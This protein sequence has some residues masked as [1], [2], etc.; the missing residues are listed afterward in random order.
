[1]RPELP[2][3]RKSG[4]RS[5]DTHCRPRRTS[6]SEAWR[7]GPMAVSRDIAPPVWGASGSGKERSDLSRQI[8]PRGACGPWRGGSRALCGHRPFPCGYGN[9]GGAC[10][11]VCWADRCVSRHQLRFVKKERARRT[12]L[13]CGRCIAAPGR[14]SQWQ[15]P[16]IFQLFH[17]LGTRRTGQN[18]GFPGPWPGLGAP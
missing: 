17:P 8:T 6:M 18:L 2:I 1:M 5:R 11:R 7:A 12:G 14:P 9:H 13:N 3:L 15:G 10:A 4:R 16:L